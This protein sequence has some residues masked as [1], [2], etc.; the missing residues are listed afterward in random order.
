MGG[1]LV[2][3]KRLTSS[4]DLY[5]L[6]H[7]GRSGVEGDVPGHEHL[8]LGVVDLLDIGSVLYRL[9]EYLHP[10]RVPIT[11]LDLRLRCISLDWLLSY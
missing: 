8:P 9:L 3:L 5:G 10:L 6:V 4:D 7:V 1:D 11:D 2:R